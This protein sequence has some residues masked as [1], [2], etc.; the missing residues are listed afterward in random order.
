MF[1][2]LGPLFAYMRRYRWQ[3]LAGTLCCVGT[4]AIWV[5]FPRVLESAVDELSHGATRGRILFL[6]GLLIAIALVKG[7]FLYAQR[8]ILIGASRE[9]EFD[10]RNDLFHLL[11]PLGGGGRREPDAATQFRQTEAGVGLQLVEELSSVRVHQCR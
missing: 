3:Y 5:Q 1:R 8:W 7:V 4:N 9:I 10:L 6:A 11:E 2:D